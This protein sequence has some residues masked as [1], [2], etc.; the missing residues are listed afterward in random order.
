MGTVYEESDYDEELGNYY[1]V[2]DA[3]GIGKC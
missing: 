2:T 1:E 3:V